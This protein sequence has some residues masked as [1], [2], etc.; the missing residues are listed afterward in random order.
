M[1]TTACLLAS[2]R[3]VPHAS[4]ATKGTRKQVT[5][6]K[7]SA[8]EHTH[9]HIHTRVAI[10]SPIQRLRTDYNTKGT[11]FLIHY[12]PGSASLL[13]S[14]Y[15]RYREERWVLGFRLRD[16]LHVTVRFDAGGP[17]SNTAAVPA[18]K[19]HIAVTIKGSLLRHKQSSEVM[20]QTLIS[21]PV[22]GGGKSELT[23]VPFVSTS[24]TSGHAARI[25][26]RFG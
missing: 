17:V 7:T 5:V 25:P 12:T 3:L 15:C 23:A 14:L 10:G 26:L 4:G 9:T 22:L 8:S 19:T 11:S 13:F 6:P 24:S 18:S 2:R 16:A 1:Y 20:L 21:R